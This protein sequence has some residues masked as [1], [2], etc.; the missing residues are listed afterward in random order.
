MKNKQT[1]FSGVMRSIK[2]TGERP[3]IAV[4]FG[5]CNEYPTILGTLFSFIE[6]LEFWG[7]PYE[8]I[9]VDNMSTDNTAWIL[10]DKLRRWVR[11]DILKVI[12]WNEKPANVTVRNVGMR[13]TDAEFVFMSDGH[14]SVKIGT[15]HGIIQK[16]IAE[17][18]RGLFHSAINIWGDT[19]DI[20]CYGYDLKLKERFW[21]NLCRGI[22]DEAWNGDIPMPYNVPMASHCCLGAGREEFLDFGG[23]AESFRCYGGGE[24]YLDLLWWLYGSKVWITPEGLFRHAFGVNAE[25]R[26]V[27]GGRMSVKDKNNVRAYIELEGDAGKER[28]ALRLLPRSTH[29]L[30]KEIKKGTFS[31]EEA[32]KQLAEIWPRIVRSRVQCKDGTQRSELLRGD[33]YLHYS[34]GYSWNNE[35]FQFNFMMSAYLIGGYKWLQSRYAAYFEGRK[36]NPR[37]V[38]ELQDLRRQVLSEGSEQ[39]KV[40][41][42]RQ[43]MSLDD[44]LERK[45]WN[46]FKTS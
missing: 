15:C 46:N 37:Y 5:V 14:I 22:P 6:E 18:K 40:I 4:V 31:A 9:V 43:I 32:I 16:W 36:G 7:Y 27:T 30:A 23:Y 38:E 34:R 21:G 1:D 13:E 2:D 35:Q 28:S 8:L 11:N 44:L 41:E 26:K 17:G 25:W 20:R 29:K 3:K 39:R 10:K 42:S 33:E 12:E 24:P 19:T 45:P